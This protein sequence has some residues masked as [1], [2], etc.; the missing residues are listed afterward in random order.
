[1]PITC[2]FIGS[3][4]PWAPRHRACPFDPGRL[5][6][7]RC[8]R[9]APAG[10]VRSARMCWRPTGSMAT[11]RRCRR[12]LPEPARPRSAGSGPMCA[13]TGPLVARP[14]GGSLRLQPRR[15]GEPPR[16][17]LKD[18]CGTLQADGYAV[19]AHRGGLLGDGPEPWPYRGVSC[20]YPAASPCAASYSSH[21]NRQ[22]RL[23]ACLPWR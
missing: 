17:H 6:R 8:L 7:A 4:G 15:K 23:A 21:A 11:T 9:A 19:R 16:R 12:W 5:G 14:A 1:M 3:R 20:R 2:R 13:I 10:R 18:F 22:A